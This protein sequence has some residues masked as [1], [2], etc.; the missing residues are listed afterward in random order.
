MDKRKLGYTIQ[1]SRYVVITRDD[2]GP[3]YWTFSNGRACIPEPHPIS[4]RK[5]IPEECIPECLNS[6]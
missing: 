4:R 1:V 6:R 5:Q 3:W 2:T